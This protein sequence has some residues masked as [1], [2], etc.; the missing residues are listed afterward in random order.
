MDESN[1]LPLVIVSIDQGVPFKKKKY[2]FILHGNILTYFK[3]GE[4]K[5]NDFFYLTLSTDENYNL[6][7]TEFA[8]AL[9]YTGPI[10]YKCKLLSKEVVSYEDFA[11]EELQEIT[12]EITEEVYLK[13]VTST[14]NNISAF[15]SEI[16][17]EE[18]IT[19]EIL[20][21]ELISFIYFVCSKVH[22]FPK[23]SL[24]YIKKSNNVINVCNEIV[25]NFFED[26][27]EKYIYVQTTQES[28]KVKIVLNYLLEANNSFINLSLKDFALL[29]QI[30][31]KSLKANNYMS[32][33]KS[34]SESSS[35]EK[36]KRRFPAYV[37][38]A[39]SKELKKLQ[40]TPPS[41]LEAQSIQTYI[42]TVRDIPWEYFAD[43]N[44]NLKLMVNE[45]NK[46]HSGLEEVKRYV[47]EHLILENHLS[48]P[49]GTVLCFVGPPGTGKT[50]I[51]KAIAKAT[52]REVIRLALGGVTDEAE[53]RGHR[54]TYVAA[55]QGRL[56]DGLIK[57]QQMNPVVILDEVDKLD[58]GT[59]GDPTSALL[60]L[61][62]PEQNSEFIDRF[63]ELPID[64]SRV[65]FICT[66]N[67]EDKIPE[68]L[69]DRLEMIYFKEYSFEER[70]DILKN[71]IYPSLVNDYEMSSFDISLSDCFFD[72]FAKEKSLRKIE[73]NVSKILKTI[74]TKFVLDE[75]TSYRLDSTAK[76]LL[77]KSKPKNNKIGFNNNEDKE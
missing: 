57:C 30:K 28:E 60:E 6:D 2:S 58:K 36:P 11:D 1:E 59:R 45:I 32:E 15:G 54:R 37:K 13:K 62:D 31:S 51:A 22:S 20:I 38:K 67:Y 74:L 71:Y 53:I 50:S 42:E 18:T 75:Q 4:L 23:E 17:Y 65:L 55:K 24:N 14:G 47:L 34:S 40:R 49:M 9:S 5:V 12:C 70:L 66:A 25:F 63:V 16:D 29:S 76:E 56:V 33:E 61:L 26:N 35:E 43:S 68:P 39:L 27:F 21:Q 69:Q 7:L 72:E 77:I 3:T 48:A 19:D 8:K 10:G 46:T 44:I 73:K 52:N 64:L 41:S